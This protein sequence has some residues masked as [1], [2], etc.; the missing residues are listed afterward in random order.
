MS[1]VEAM[2]AGKPVIGVAEGGLLETVVHNETGVLLA[3][4][5]THEAV[6]AAVEQIEKMRGPRMSEVCRK[7]ANLFSEA[8]FIQRIRSVIS[9]QASS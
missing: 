4:P 7:R 2:A 9:P 3:T 1:P 5:P 8:T 6:I